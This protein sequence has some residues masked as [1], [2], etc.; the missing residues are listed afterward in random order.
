MKNVNNEKYIDT[1]KSLP[2]GSIWLLCNIKI[3]NEFIYGGAKEKDIGRLYC[4]PRIY[5]YSLLKILFYYIKQ[6]FILRVKPYLK[7]APFILKVSRGYDHKNILKTLKLSEDETILV[8]VFNF[9]DLMK[10]EKVSLNSLIKNL[11]YLIKCLDTIKISPSLPSNVIKIANNEGYKNIATYAYLL[12][13]FAKFKENNEESS[14]CSGGGW[15]ASH[16]AIFAG[17]R[18]SFMCHGLMGLVYIALMPKFNTIYVYSEDEKIYLRSIGILSN[19]RIYPF[20][21]LHSRNKLVVIFSR[22]EGEGIDY[23]ILESIV[24]LFK[25]FGY[26][27]HLRGHPRVPMSK[28]LREWC[29]NNGLTII[30]NDINQ[31]GSSIIEKIEPSFVIG[32][33][34]TVLCESLNMGVIPINAWGNKAIGLIQ[35][36]N[37]GPYN[38][39]K[40]CFSWETEKRTIDDILL[41]RI[42]YN[43]ALH[44]LNSR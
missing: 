37:D 23:K 20:R 39:D 1:I 12:S 5:L 24:G 26:H 15:V 29:N 10:L 35:N 2:S 30:A 22:E 41:E 11:I 42:G 40:R 16:I 31:N 7:D 6:Y 38:F 21:K 44:T 28:E 19:I 27:I 13:F 17:I 3:Q 25:H 32:V 36:M 4:G 43:E 18:C 34:S 14:I 8:D 9:N 33:L